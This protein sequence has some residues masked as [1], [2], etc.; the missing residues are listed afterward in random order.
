M[1]QIVSIFSGYFGYVKS[2]DVK[3]VKRINQ[4][5]KEKSKEAR[6]LPG[7]TMRSPRP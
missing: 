3:L 4:Y 6:R 5:V 7:R 1:R 2:P